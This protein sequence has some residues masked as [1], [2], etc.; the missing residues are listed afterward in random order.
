MWPVEMDRS[1]INQV[2]QNLIVN[3]DQA[4]VDGGTM[5]I[6]CRNE[7]LAHDQISDLAG[8]RYVCVAVQ[9]QG[10]GIPEDILDKIFDPYFSTKQ[11]DSNKGNGLGL[12]IVHSI[13]T[14]HSGIIQV[15]SKLDEGS[16]F[17]MY[18]P[19]MQEKISSSPVGE[20]KVTSGRGRI[21]VMDD[22]EMIR[23]VVCNMLEYLGYETVQACDG[24]EAVEL[25]RQ[26]L[27]NGEKFRGVIMDLTIPGGMGG[28]EATRQIS[29]IDTEAKVIVSSGYS[30]D[31][32]LDN[33]ESFGFCNIVSKPYQLADLSRVLTET[34]A[35][36][37]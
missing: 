29:N 23:T 34:L 21:L 2:I 35:G 11:R 18:L 14:K 32:V 33:F 1:Q 9:D 7:I 24:Q 8:G 31:P 37:N 25:Y 4:M 12:S 28:V 30:H 15:D 6:S 26:G 13:V 36:K 22:E 10:R 19:A 20:E 5:H 3:A 16:T 17:T 27:E